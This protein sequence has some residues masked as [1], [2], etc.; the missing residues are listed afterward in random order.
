VGGFDLVVFV[1]LFLFDLSEPIAVAIAVLDFVG[2]F[3]KFF[4][5]CFG[6]SVEAYGEID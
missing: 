2:E 5:F 1:H 4:E 6:I 3:Y